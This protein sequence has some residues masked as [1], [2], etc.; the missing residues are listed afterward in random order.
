MQYKSESRFRNQLVNT[1]RQEGFKVQAVE[2]GGTGLGVPDVFF[3]R[4][5]LSGWMELKNMQDDILPDTITIDFRPG[6]IRWLTEF[7]DEGVNVYLVVS[8]ID[9]VFFFRNSEIKQEY[10]L[11][12]FLEQRHIT[13]L[14][15]IDAM[16]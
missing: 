2:T 8:C 11:K 14:K 6:Q 15:E 10:T 13:K 12:E 1:M 3:A 7:K 9:G 4:S 16:L 5:G